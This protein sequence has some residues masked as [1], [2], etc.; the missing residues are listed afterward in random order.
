MVVPDAEISAVQVFAM[1]SG[2]TINPTAKASEELNRTCPL[3]N[4]T[5]QLS[6]PAMHIVTDRQRT[7][8]IIVTI[9]DH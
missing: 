6:T 2:Y 8:D 1:C 9:A 5:A 3:K 4:T 7:D